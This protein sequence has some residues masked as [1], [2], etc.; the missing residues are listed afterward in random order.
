MTIYTH[1]INLLTCRL[2]TNVVN[3]RKAVQHVIERV[4][5]T[6]RRLVLAIPL[7]AGRSHILNNAV[8]DAV[9]ENIVVVTSAGKKNY[10]NIVYSCAYS[11]NM[12]M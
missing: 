10:Y 1:S 5:K 12:C 11:H 9:K 6:G 7:V 3:M 8:E 4:K 2:S